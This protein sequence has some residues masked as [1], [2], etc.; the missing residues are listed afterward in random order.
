M[1]EIK[2]MEKYETKPLPEYVNKP[3][4]ANV[5][6][7]VLGLIATTAATA[8]YTMV[9]SELNGILLTG[10]LGLTLSA[11]VVTADSLPN[12]EEIKTK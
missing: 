3:I 4:F 6:R 12:K 11:M 5:G 7:V 10:A 2:E 8:T 1:T 9:P